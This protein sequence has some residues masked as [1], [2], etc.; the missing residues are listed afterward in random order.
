MVRPAQRHAR[1]RGRRPT[2]PHA[3][4]IA[5]G[6]GGDAV[7]LAQRNGVT[8]TDWAAGG[9]A[10]GEATAAERGVADR[11]TW[12]Q[13]D[14]LDDGWDDEALRPGHVALHLHLPPALRTPAVARMAS[15][16][17]GPAG[18]SWSSA[19]TRPTSTSM[20]RTSQVFADAD[21]ITVL[22]PAQWEVVTA[23]AR[24]RDA[25]DPEGSPSSCTTRSSA[26]VVA[27]DAGALPAERSGEPRRTVATASRVPGGPDQEAT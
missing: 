5:A 17:P 8:A 10:R 3:L 26:H 15:L 24:P 27:P 19:T 9:L 4:D 25:V 22:D 23:E 12:R 14:I 21:E 11:V 6:E 7:W 18:R 20:R 16:V 13:A 1:R 2:C